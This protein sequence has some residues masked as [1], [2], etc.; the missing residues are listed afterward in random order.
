[1]VGDFKKETGAEKINAIFLTDGGADYCSDY[2]DSETQE[3]KQVYSSLHRADK[4]YLVIRDNVTKRLVHTDGTRQNLTNSLLKNLGNRHNINVIGFHITDR[5]TINRDIQYGAG[6]ARAAELKSF[7]NKN[8]Y[9]PMK[10]SGYATYFL[11][12]DKSLDQEAKFDTTGTVDDSGNVAKG[13]LR[14]QFRK[15]TSA[16][17]VNKMMLN[18]FVALVA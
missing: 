4:K 18:E 17:K 10:E 7:V 6:Y 5:K 16:R 15:F 11:V 1:M 9:V 13:K 12:N 8:G 2:W 3:K 14:T